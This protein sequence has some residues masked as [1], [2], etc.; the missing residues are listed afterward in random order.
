MAPVHI[1]NGAVLVASGG[2]ALPLFSDTALPVIAK[3]TEDVLIQELGYIGESF[4]TPPPPPTLPVPTQPVAAP[5][6]V[7]AGNQTTCPQ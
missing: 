6:A 3:P 5:L 7:P 4:E 2:T 1:M